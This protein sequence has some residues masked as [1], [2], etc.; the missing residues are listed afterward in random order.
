MKLN[1]KNIIAELAIITI[2]ALPILVSGQ[3]PIIPGEQPAPITTLTE[4]RGAITVIVRWIIAV[5]WI[6]TVL[7]LIIAAFRYLTAAGD[8]EKLGKAKQSLIFAIIAA[9]IALLANGIQLIVK[10]LLQQGTGGI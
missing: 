9:A 6:I 10:N 1:L 2:V 3:Q 7:F 8:P 5:F 4:A